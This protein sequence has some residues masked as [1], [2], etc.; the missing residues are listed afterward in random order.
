MH[1]TDRNVDT[2]VSNLFGCDCL[3]TL[4]ISEPEASGVPTR[5]GDLP[6]A[7]SASPD[8]STWLATVDPIPVIAWT[9]ASVIAGFEPTSLYVETT[10]RGVRFEAGEF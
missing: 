4:D 8:G 2:S 7:R 1:P 3:E 10:G 9:D 5:R 6:V